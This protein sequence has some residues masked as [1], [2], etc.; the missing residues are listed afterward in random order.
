MS[1]AELRT[2]AVYVSTIAM[3]VHT[4]LQLIT[5]CPQ[6]NVV[7]ASPIAATIAV[8]DDNIKFC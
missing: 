1:V 6:L 4:R 2:N 3:T 5:L 8:T 7:D